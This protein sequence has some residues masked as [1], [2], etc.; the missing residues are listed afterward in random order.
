[1]PLVGQVGSGVFRVEWS[2]G[3]FGFW[4][5]LHLDDDDVTLSE[6]EKTLLDYVICR[7]LFGSFLFGLALVN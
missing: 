4:F 7:P 6:L 2:F 3:R 5:F 1:M